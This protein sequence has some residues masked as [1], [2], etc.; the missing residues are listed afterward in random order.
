MLPTAQIMPRGIGP[1]ILPRARDARGV[2][3]TRRASYLRYR[4]Q[5]L[6]SGW[7]GLGRRVHRRR[8]GADSFFS[9][10]QSVVTPTESQTPGFDYEKVW[11][12]AMPVRQRQIE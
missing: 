7:L 9:Q 1:R 6:P 4:H 2:G 10:D 11:Y 5:Q 12:P 8:V 3:P